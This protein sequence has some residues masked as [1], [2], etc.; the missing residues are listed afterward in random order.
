VVDTWT[1]IDVIS[2]CMNLF[3]FN[4]IGSVSVSQIMTVS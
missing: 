3:C 2:A 1:V 4:V